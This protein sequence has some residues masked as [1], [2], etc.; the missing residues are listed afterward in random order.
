L[1]PAT[2]REVAGKLG[3][4][5][6]QDRLHS[7]PQYNIT[8]GSTYFQQMLRYYGGSYPLAVAAYNGGPGNVNRWLRENGDPRAGG[9][10]ILKW[11]EDI[12]LA[13][14]KY[15]VQYVLSNA[16]MYDQIRQANG[17]KAPDNLL[18]FYLGKRNP[19]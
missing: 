7:D 17:G 19:G 15:Y 11:I 6:S 1:M 9:V 2:A 8:L 16:V 14:T 13:E 3:L 5:H 4:A 12:P 10:D 18:S